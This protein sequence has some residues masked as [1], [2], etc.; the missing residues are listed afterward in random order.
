MLFS[1]VMRRL[2]QEGDRAISPKERRAS[3]N[4]DRAISCTRSLLSALALALL[5]MLAPGAGGCLGE[6]DPQDDLS[7]Q[8]ARYPELGRRSIDQQTPGFISLTFD[9]GPSEYTKDIVDTLVR[10]R[11]QA[12]FFQVGRLIAGRRD[13]LDYQK[14]NGQQLASHSYNHEAQPSLTE[15]VFKHRIKAV[16]LNIGDDDNG[17]L[18]FRFPFGAATE[19]TLRWLSEV[20]IDGKHYRPVG[21]HCDSHDF[22][23]DVKYPAEEYS[24]IVITGEK[25]PNQGVCDGQANPFQRDMVGWTQFIARRTKGGVMLYHDTKRITRDKL[26]D[27]ISFFEN[28]DR[29]WTSL[30][31]PRRAELEK[32]YAC[33]KVDRLLRFDFKPLWDG[34]YPSLRD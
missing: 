21:W 6:N 32:Y 23:Y 11:I 34:T 20:D 22:D 26:E 28:P 8:L 25:L 10:H 9:D 17:R 12:T 3:Q 13:V 30:P 4:E 7:A 27:I 29:Y 5:C 15:E 16:K 2:G 18:Y 14:A 31:A 19:E 24:D 1:S 33:Q